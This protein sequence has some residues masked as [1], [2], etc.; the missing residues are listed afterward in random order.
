LKNGLFTGGETQENSYSLRMGAAL[1]RKRRYARCG[2]VFGERYGNW[3]G[4][5]LRRP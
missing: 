5:C 2:G 4:W 1:R 3:R